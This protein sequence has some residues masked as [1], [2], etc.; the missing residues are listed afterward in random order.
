MLTPRE[1]VRVALSHNE[2]DR[3]P[4][5]NNG[6]V[7]GMHIE[8]Y[9]RLLSILNMKDEI[10]VLDLVQ[11][12]ALVNENIMDLLGVDTRYIYARAGMNY[13]SKVN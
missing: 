2:P 10:A 7:S 13:Q 4:I 9:K 6:F 5:D 11:K 8:A 3:V 12:L 1:R